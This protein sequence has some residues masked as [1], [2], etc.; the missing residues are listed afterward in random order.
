[1]PSA[2]RLAGALC[3]GA[4]G[5][6]VSTLIIPLLPEGT[7]PGYFVWVNL[8]LGLLVGWMVIGTRMGR[9]WTPAINVGLTAVVVLV[10]WGLFIQGCN[11]MVAL[12]M[13]NRYK[14]PFEAIVAVFEIA[15]EYALI[16][17]TV[18]VIGTLLIGGALT[19]IAA[20]IAQRNWR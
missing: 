9:G 8:V 19:G 10:G 7:D 4:L 2:A 3:L 15:I 1:M 12:A 16:M 20:E 13:K 17:A 11:E 14:G 5:F 18:P 6:Y